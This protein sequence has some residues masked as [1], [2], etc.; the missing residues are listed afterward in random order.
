VNAED[1]EEA[2]A[3]LDDIGDAADPAAILVPFPKFMMHFKLPEKMAEGDD[4]NALLPPLIFDGFD[5][6][7]DEFLA[8]QFYPSFHEAAKSID[9]DADPGTSDDEALEALNNALAE[10]KARLWIEEESRQPHAAPKRLM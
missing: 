10:E 5:W 9:F 4:M 6:D 2:A 7:T 1:E 8:E 3:R